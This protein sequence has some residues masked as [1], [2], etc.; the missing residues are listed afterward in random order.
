M[1][2]VGVVWEIVQCERGEQRYRLE[3]CRK[4]NRMNIAKNGFL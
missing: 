3:L 2:A 1:I 4:A